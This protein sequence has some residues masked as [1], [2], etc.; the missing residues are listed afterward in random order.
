MKSEFAVVT[1]ASEGLGK[2][3]AI[4]LSRMGINTILI[5]LGD[6]KLPEVAGHCRS[7]GTRCEYFETDMTDEDG[8]IQVCR[9]IS[10]SFSIFMLINNAG[11]GGTKAFTGCGVEYLQRIM[12]LNIIATTIMTHQLLPSLM[13]AERAYI[14]NVSSMAA[15][16]PIAFKTIYPA[17]KRY[18][19]DFT[20]GLREEL[21]GTNV[22]VSVVHPGP[23]KTNTDVTARIEKQGIF[24]RVGLLSPQ[25]VARKSLRKTLR[26]RMVIIP[27][28]LNRMNRVL[29]EVVPPGICIPLLSKIVARELKTSKIC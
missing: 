18:I 22:S 13:K 20:R 11:T 4:E 2:N 1:G 10:S 27:G 21:S 5:A 8:L 25:A 12:H 19:A 6:G 24:G 3:F 28:W 17:S 14:L 16:S 23:M 15:F 7:F 26:R 29:L 9:E